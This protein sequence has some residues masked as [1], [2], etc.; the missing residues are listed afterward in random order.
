MH[1]IQNFNGWKST[2]IK[3]NKIDGFIKTHNGIRCVV[4]FDHGWFNKVC[5]RINILKIKKSGI[6]DSTDSINH[7]FGKN[8]N[9]FI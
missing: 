5:D 7:N 6:L 1:F 8:Q 4:L 2:H 3:F 9:W